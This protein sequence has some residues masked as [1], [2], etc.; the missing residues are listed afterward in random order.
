MF[1]L[2]HTGEKNYVCRS[3]GKSFRTSSEAYNCE[4]GHQG[5]FKW[6]CALCSFKSHQRNKYVRHLRTHTK[7]QPYQ[8]PLCDHKSA[9]KDYLQKHIGK[10]H[11]HLSLDEIE[12][13]YPNLYKIEEKIQV[14]SQMQYEKLNLHVDGQIEIDKGSSIPLF[15]KNIMVNSLHVLKDGKESSEAGTHSTL[16]DDMRVR[17]TVPFSH[18]NQNHCA[19]PSTL[20]QHYL[21]ENRKM[22]HINIPPRP[23]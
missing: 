6:R 23:L 11:S 9:R 15:G 1:F 3:C 12:A 20:L 18:Q 16:R 5:I 13:K 8:C 17:L 7:S 4:R 21:A 19:L 14:T 2:G 10:T 22:S